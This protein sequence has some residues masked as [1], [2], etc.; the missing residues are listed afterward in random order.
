MRQE[1]IRRRRELGWSQ[2]KIA[3]HVGAALGS[4]NTWITEQPKHGI[5]EHNLK[6]FTNGTAKPSTY[7]AINQ[8]H[9]MDAAASMNRLPRHVGYHRK[10]K[11][12]LNTYGS[13]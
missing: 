8:V 5:G 11:S 10:S 6:T 1:A 4:V 3:A 9:I 13:T 12:T 7:L 2:R